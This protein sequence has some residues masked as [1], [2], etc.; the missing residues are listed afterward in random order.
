MRRCSA[1]TAA[2]VSVAGALAILASVASAKDARRFDVQVTV[3]QI[4]EKAGK[5]DPRTRR[6]DE[7]IRKQF[8]YESLQFLDEKKL[9]LA[10]DEVGSVR[11]PTGDMFR[12]R[13]LNLGDRGLLMAVGWEGE[14][15]MDMHARS[16]HLLVIGGPDYKGG[17]L[18]ISI[19]PTY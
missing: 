3:T 7:A 14:M 16:G 12:V 18:V 10:I 8:R 1:Q 19:E 2:W 11:L 4:S 5:A 13:P 17:R 15:Q 9:E 6:L